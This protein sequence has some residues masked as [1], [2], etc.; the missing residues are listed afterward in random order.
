MD[1]ISAAAQL[2]VDQVLLAQAVA[3]SPPNLS[4]MPAEELPVPPPPPM[5]RFPKVLRGA[6]PSASGLIGA[7]SDYYRLAHYPPGFIGPRPK[8][9]KSDSQKRKDK[10]ICTHP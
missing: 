3:A 8:R 7:S 9:E 10:Q 5:M 4:A 2:A 1:V 6:L